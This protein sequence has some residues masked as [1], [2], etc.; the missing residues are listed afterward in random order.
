MYVEDTSPWFIISTKPKQEFVAERNLKRLGVG[1]YLPI[2]FKKI[3]KNKEKVEVIAPLFSG[4]IFAQFSV[5][6]SYH[7]VIYTRGIKNVLGNREGLWTIEGR[8]VDDIK[9]RENNGVV[10]L[11]KWN[12]NFKKGDK[13][14]IDEG[15]FDGWEGIFSEELP[16]R[17]RAVILLTNVGFSSKLIVQKSFL[18]LHT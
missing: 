12:P 10:V 16:D 4:Y 6:Q 18:K 1:V 3:K 13:I 15:D 17:Q 7:S 2:Y 11:R 9:Q 5:D 14:L 8:K